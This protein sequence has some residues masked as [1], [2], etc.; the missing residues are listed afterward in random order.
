M[1]KKRITEM[2]CLKSVVKIGIAMSIVI[3]LSS[4]KDDDDEDLVGNWVKLGEYSGDGRSDAVGVALGDKAYVGLGYDGEDRRIDFWEYD[5]INDY[6]S[7]KTDFPGAARN[8]AVGFSAS[9]KV[10]FGTGY[11]G[12][13]KLKDFYAFDPSTN[14]WTQI[15]D[16]PGS[17]RY[18]ALA[19]SIG[20]K[21]FVGTGYDGSYNK[22]F[23]EYD[24][25][26]SQWTEVVSIPYKRRDAM[27]FV[28]NG[29]GYVVGGINNGTYNS[30]FSKYDPVTNSWTTLRKISDA[31]DEDFDD[32]YDITRI[33]AAAFVVNEKGYIATGGRSTTGGDVWEYNPATDLWI[34]KT[35][36]YEDG[37][38]GA[39]RTEAI[40]F[41]IDGIGY[42]L[43][44]RNSSYYFDD[45]LR[46]E[47]YA[48][49]NEYD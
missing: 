14:E 1:I 16:F 29:E 19:M 49:M 7:Q 21:G 6:W 26:T 40:G 2:I 35:E 28:I 25:S 46:F 36:I 17:A 39:E 32:E 12:T 3:S 15:D 27:T 23:Y 30:D 34:E 31:T 18:G 8:G 9:E 41:T 47:P 45:V 13:N 24:P 4:C 42:V 33:N 44:G 5:P 20:D 22:D 43:L 38:G 37:E 48:E 10:F 11:D